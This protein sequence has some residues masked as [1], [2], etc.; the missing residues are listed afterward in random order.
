M[1]KKI[2]AN[3]NPPSKSYKFPGGCVHFLIR[4]TGFFLKFQSFEA[5]I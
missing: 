1:F 5:L 2:I 4:H 3:I